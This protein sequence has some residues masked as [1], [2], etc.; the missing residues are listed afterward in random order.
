MMDAEWVSCPDEVKCPHCQAK[1]E[2]Y[3][4]EDEE[5]DDDE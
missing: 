1:F 5:D 4:R 2:T 3:H